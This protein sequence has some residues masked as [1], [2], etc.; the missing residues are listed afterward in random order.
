MNTLGIL[1]VSFFKG[2]MLLIDEVRRTP[3]A[4]VGI[5]LTVVVT[6]TLIA[7]LAHG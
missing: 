3:T 6:G 7:I 5:M 4:W 2:I 1:V